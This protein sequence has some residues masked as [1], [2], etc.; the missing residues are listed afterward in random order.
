MVSIRGG[1]LASQ[2]GKYVMF[3][4]KCDKC[5]YEEQGKNTT[6]IRPGAMKVPWF[7]RKCRKGR[8][9]EMVAVG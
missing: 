4:K 1:V 9:V 5:G 8:M 3:R 2:D 6:L 7:C